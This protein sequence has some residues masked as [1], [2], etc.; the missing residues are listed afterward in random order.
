MR[1][2]LAA[3]S[4]KAL[5]PNDALRHELRTL[6]KRAAYTGDWTYRSP[7]QLEGTLPRVARAN[8]SFVAPTRSHSRLGKLAIRPV[9]VR[10]E[11]RF[12]NKVDFT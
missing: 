7:A 1:L 5:Q 2:V 8:L 9:A 11:S 10:H 12:G 3:L 6:D 4:E